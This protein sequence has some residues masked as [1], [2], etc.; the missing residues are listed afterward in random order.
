MVFLIL[1]LDQILINQDKIQGLV[2]EFHNSDLFE[3]K[4]IKFIKNFKL[5]LV[6]IHVNN[7]SPPNINNFATAI[8]L[9]F[10]SKC[11]KNKNHNLYPVEGL[12]HPNNLMEIDQKSSIIINVWNICQMV[13]E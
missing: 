10:A 8:E 13:T 4:I 12:D 9:S 7:F 3:D 11:V 2:I 6:H 5:H 1:I